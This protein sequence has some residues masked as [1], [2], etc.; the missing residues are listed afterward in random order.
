M[1]QIENAVVQASQKDSMKYLEIVSAQPMHGNHF[2]VYNKAGEFVG[3]VTFVDGEIV[4]F[5]AV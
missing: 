1:Q 5:Y 2:A 3:Q 4:A